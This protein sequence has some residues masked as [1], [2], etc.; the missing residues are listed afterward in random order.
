MEGLGVTVIT[1]V[2]AMH[3][4]DRDCIEIDV[5]EASNIHSP[6]VRGSSWAPKRQD[7]ANGAEVVLGSLRIPFIQ[8]QFFKWREEL[9]IS[10]FNS[11]I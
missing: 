6:L 5:I 2:A 11:V 9:Q 7:S 4:L 10:F 3:I 1:E 8:G